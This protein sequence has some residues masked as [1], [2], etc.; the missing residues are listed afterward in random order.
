MAQKP[1]TYLIENYRFGNVQKFIESDQKNVCK[2]Q[3]ILKL[4][5]HLFC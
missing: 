3:N 1:S 5:N 2:V 4:K